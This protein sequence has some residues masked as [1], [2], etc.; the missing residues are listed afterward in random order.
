MPRN[1]NSIDM[2]NG[3]LAGKILLFALPFA[4]SSILQQAFNSADFAV[5]GRF[6]GS[7]SLAAVG[8]N[9]PIINLIINI[10]VGLSLGANVV[11]A[12]LIGQNRKDEVKSAVHTVVLVAIISGVFLAVAGNIVSVHIL[13]AIHTPDSVLHLASLYLRIYFLGMPAVMLYNFGSAILRSKGDSRRPFFALVA[14]GILNV[15]LNLVF[16]VL[17]G[18]GVAGVAI[19]T[20]IANCLSASIVVFLLLREDDPLRLNFK[21]LH[22]NRVVLTKI[23]K[24]GIPAGI[25]GMVFSFSNICLQGGINSFGSNAM[26]GSAAALNFEYFSYFVVNAFTQSA[27][28]FTS[29]NFGAKDFSRCKRIYAICMTFGLL[30]TGLMCESFVIFRRHLVLIYTTDPAVIPFALSRMFIVESVEFLTGT[31]EIT[32]GAMRGMGSSLLPALLTM[33]GSCLLRIV[34]LETVFKRFPSFETIMKV[35]PVSWIITGTAV[36][37]AYLV[38]RGRKFR[39]EG[40]KQKT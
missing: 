6:S 31:Y 13:R 28:T 33:A 9:A 35:Y 7:E 22:I 37:I 26:A 38:V 10:F 4:A 15:S 30:L 32:A 23:A 8:N 18:M 20:V 24:I 40:E 11:I 19:A 1:K 5:V 29:Q 3:P 27:T 21:S 14:G 16:V 17:L 36:I 25:Q 12:T 34:W 2:L 39:S